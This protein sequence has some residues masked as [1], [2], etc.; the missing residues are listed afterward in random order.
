MARSP[1]DP[2]QGILPPDAAI[3]RMQKHEMKEYIYSLGEQLSGLKNAA[4]DAVQYHRVMALLQNTSMEHG[5]C[6]P[7]ERR[8]C[9]HCNA[10]DDLKKMTD[11]YK[12]PRV[13][14][15]GLTFS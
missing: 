9:T 10:V 11:E 6:Q 8:A 3:A 4:K 1:L 14:T 13:T 2:L 15:S 5:T 7:R 12:G